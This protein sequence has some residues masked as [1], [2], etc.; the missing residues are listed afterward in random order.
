MKAK[1]IDENQPALVARSKEKLWLAFHLQV[2][3]KS[4]GFTLQ[5]EYR[6]SDRRFRADWFV[7]EL[8]VLIE[9]E[10]IL[11]AKS[12]H[13]SVTGFT[14]DSE[15]YNLAAVMGFKVLR[16]TALNYRTVITD[17]EK[18]KPATWPTQ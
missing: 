7:K 10:G 5:A 14:K 1:R 12:R 4:K 18:L 15:K 16:Y 9:Y 6:F 3:C 17:L 11:S 13:T 2:W 8:S